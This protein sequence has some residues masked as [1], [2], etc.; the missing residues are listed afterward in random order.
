MLWP[1]LRLDKDGRDLE[2]KLVQSPSTLPLFTTPLWVND[3]SSVFFFDSESH[4]DPLAV[5]P[6][7][8]THLSG[9]G[10]GRGKL[11]KRIVDFTKRKSAIKS[12]TVEIG[13][14]CSSISQCN[15]KDLSHSMVASNADRM[16]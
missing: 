1:S 5:N 12:V 7:C 13:L 6:N 16:V 8:T 10:P 2:K 3:Y 4:L 9:I 15:L 11:P 14:L